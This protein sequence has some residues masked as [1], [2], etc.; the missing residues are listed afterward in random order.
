MEINKQKEDLMSK[1]KMMN[2]LKMEMNNKEAEYSNQIEI[3]QVKFEEKNKELLTV[4]KKYEALEKELIEMV[5]KSYI[6]YLT[7]YYNY[8]IF[9]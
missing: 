1:D 5:R 7:L 9:L 4:Q 3:L 2:G 8:F 6:H